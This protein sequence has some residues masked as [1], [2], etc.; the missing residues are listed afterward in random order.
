AVSEAINEKLFEVISVS[1]LSWAKMSKIE[2]AIGLNIIKIGVKDFPDTSIIECNGFKWDMEKD[3][4]KQ[5]QDV[6]D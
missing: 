1:Q 4:D 3:K 2:K 5:M 6:K